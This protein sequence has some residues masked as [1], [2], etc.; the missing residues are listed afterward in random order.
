MDD[1]VRL[2]ALGNGTLRK[3]GE[4]IVKDK[5]KKK[6]KLDEIMSGLQSGRKK[7]TK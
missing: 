5:K 7:P 3:A 6:S 2:G 1:R 4:D